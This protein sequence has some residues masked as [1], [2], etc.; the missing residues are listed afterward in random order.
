MDGTP[1]A[2][3]FT[4]KNPIY[5]WMIWGYPYLILFQE[6]P[7]KYLHRIPT[8]VPDSP[9]LKKPSPFS[10]LQCVRVVLHGTSS[11]K[12]QL[13]QLGQYQFDGSGFA[14]E[15]KLIMTDLQSLSREHLNECLIVFGASIHVQ[16]S[17]IE[18]SCWSWATLIRLNT[19]P[20]TGREP[21]HCPED[22]VGTLKKSKDTE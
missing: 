17:K 10:P 22:G 20:V 16:T 15:R 4:M 14:S 7:L 13:E 1:I 5:K 9:Q 21:V 6:T 19:R 2:G 3:W 18:E 11:V 12:K 8:L